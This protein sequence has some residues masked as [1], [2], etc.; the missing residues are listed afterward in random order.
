MEKSYS[1]YEIKETS[2]KLHGSSTIATKA[3]CVGSLEEELDAKVVSKKCEGV[4]VKKRVHGTG[5]GKLKLSLHMRYDVFTSVFGM[6]FAENKKGVYS[7][8]KNSIHPSF[9]LTGKVY[10]EDG[11]EKLKAYPNCIIETG[12]ARKIENGAE[13][14][15]EMEIEISVMPDETTGQG[16]YEAIISEVTDDTVKE[17]WLTDFTPDLVKEVVA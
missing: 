11:E 8:G 17:K 10:D 12:M 1:E 5:T 9:C 13:E 16:M 3:G 14:V 15:A 2:I 7:Y 4:V 6:L